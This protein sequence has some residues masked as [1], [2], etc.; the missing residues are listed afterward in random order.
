[1]PHGI[2]PSEIWA[3]LPAET[4][5]EICG[6][7]IWSA[8]LPRPPYPWKSLSPGWSCLVGFMGPG[9][10]VIIPWKMLCLTARLDA[11][12]LSPP[13]PVGR[14]WAGQLA[15]LCLGFPNKKHRF[16]HRLF[17]LLRK[18]TKIMAKWQKCFECFRKLMPAQCWINVLRVP[19]KKTGICS[20]RQILQRCNDRPTIVT[21]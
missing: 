5:K 19:S 6:E 1:M 20:L 15:F 8:S 11:S 14:L 13:E 9:V 17:F 10:Y 4:I 21:V 16:G 7:G 12:C 18:A 2:F 3:H